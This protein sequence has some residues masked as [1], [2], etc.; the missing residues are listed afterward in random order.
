MTN[1]AQTARPRRRLA[2]LVDLVAPS[3]AS[4]SSE[5]SYSVRR[6]V[7]LGGEK[8]HALLKERVGVWA[9]G[10]MNGPLYVLAY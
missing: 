8:G 1:P 7:D 4:L 6:G 5:K 3:I 2:A 10:P 9:S